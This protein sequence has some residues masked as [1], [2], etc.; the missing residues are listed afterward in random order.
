ML[1]LTPDWGLGHGRTGKQERA[2]VENL[3][4]DGC[5]IVIPNLYFLRVTGHVPMPFFIENSTPG[6]Y[7]TP[8]LLLVVL[9]PSPLHINK[10]DITISSTAPVLTM[11]MSVS[12]KQNNMYMSP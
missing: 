1:T 12:S 8:N 5:E 9:I 6:S 4:D 7:M 2:Q 11:V 10:T 3:H